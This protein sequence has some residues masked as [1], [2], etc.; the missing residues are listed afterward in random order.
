MINQPVYS[1]SPFAVATNGLKITQITQPKRSDQIVT[2]L[3]NAEVS[4]ET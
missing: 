1:C 3:L 4:H 2:L